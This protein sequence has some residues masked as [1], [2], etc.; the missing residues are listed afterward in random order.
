MELVVARAESM[1]R[2][3]IPQRP[4]DRRASIVFLCRQVELRVN[5]E[6]K[7]ISKFDADANLV[8]S[9]FAKAPGLASLGAPTSMSAEK[10]HDCAKS[11]PWR[12]E[13]LVPALINWIVRFY[14]VDVYFRDG[15]I[16][17]WT[18]RYRFTTWLGIL[19]EAR[20]FIIDDNFM[21]A[22]CGTRHLSNG[23]IIAC[24]FI[25]K[26]FF[27]RSLLLFLCQDVGG[28]VW[29]VISHALTKLKASLWRLIVVKNNFLVWRHPLD[30][31]CTIRVY[32]WGICVINDLIIAFFWKDAFLFTVSWFCR[33]GLGNW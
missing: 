16:R 4:H 1:R 22:R 10:W 27:L 23:H 5:V 13:L 24:R 19:I 33:L 25:L 3:L 7:L 14:H 30:L 6:E 12:D 26:Y 15:E 8:E 17:H 21:S 9:S 2:I 29:H 31:H 11:V 20:H 28:I 32:I 18:L